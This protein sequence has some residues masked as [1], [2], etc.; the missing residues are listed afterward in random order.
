MA[1]IDRRTLIVLEVASDTLRQEVDRGTQDPER[2]HVVMEIVGAL[3]SRE[4][5]RLL[6]A[7]DDDTT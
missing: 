5:N 2:L 4:R 6:T 1:A 7:A 3:L